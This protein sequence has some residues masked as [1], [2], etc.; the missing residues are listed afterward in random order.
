MQRTENDPTGQ[1]FRFSPEDLKD[2]YLDITV[3]SLEHTYT[4][5]HTHTHTH[6]RELASRIKKFHE[7]EIIEVYIILIIL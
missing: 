1:I 7:L 3:N 5:T 4:H 6:T 2:A